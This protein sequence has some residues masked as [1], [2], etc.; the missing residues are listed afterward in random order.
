M[1]TW[2]FFSSLGL[3]LGLLV[4]PT[5][6]QKNVTHDFHANYYLPRQQKSD[7]KYENNMILGQS[8]SV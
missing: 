6:R 2:R 8:A 3:Y 1:F 7:E 4:P 5:M